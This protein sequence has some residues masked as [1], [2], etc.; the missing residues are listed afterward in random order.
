MIS[1]NAAWDV[2]GKV[3]LVTGANSGI[4][5]ATATELASRG[6]RVVL[7]SRDMDKGLVAK[8]EIEVASGATVDLREL[9]LASFR[10]ITA[11]A[12]AFLAEYS[13]L[14][15][16]VHNAGLV[17]SDRRETEDGIEATFGINH[18]GAFTLNR[19]LLPLLEKSAPARI[20]VV[21]SDAHKGAW[22]GLDFDDLQAK[23][24]YQGIRAYSNSKLANI[25]FTRHLSSL[26]K[27]SGVSAFCLHP[28]V[29]ATNITG[30]GDAGGLWRF[31]FKWL[32]PFLLTAEKGARTS[33]YLCC[34]PDIEELSGEYFVKCRQTKPSKAALDAAAALQLWEAS[35]VL[36]AEAVLPAYNS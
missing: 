21:A 29:V 10:S 23:H 4:G 1:K 22:R 25:L 28:G 12:Q 27:G 20:V 8:A 36:S 7:T 34:Q 3:V 24:S 32:R 35:E 13:S 17:L 15:V 2:R 5:K 9:D 11:F 18:L 6:A 31:L 33:V 16:L 19:L 30:D 14:H 26:I